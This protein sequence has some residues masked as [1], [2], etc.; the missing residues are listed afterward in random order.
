MNEA[1]SAVAETVGAQP[2]APQVVLACH[3]LRKIYQQGANDVPV[4]LNVDLEVHKGETVAIVGASGSGKSTLLHLLG[5]LDDASGG[6]VSVL[7]RELSR[8][9]ESE[10]GLLRNRGLGFVYQFHHLLPEFTALENVAMPLLVRRLSVAQASQK[11]KA[12]L[13]R[14]GLGHRLTHTPGELS[15]GERQRAALARALV[16]EPACVL[17]DEPTGNLDR[18]TAEGVLELMMQLNRDLGTSFVVVTHDPGIAARMNRILTLEDGHLK[19][20]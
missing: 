5:G 8:V 7:G 3:A 1:G 11:A 20:S 13:E 16:T 15:G 14:V 9:S 12:M 2:L 19:A 17:A 18:R 6:K 4:L 10:R